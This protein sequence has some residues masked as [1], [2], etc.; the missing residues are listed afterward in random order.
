MAQSIYKDIGGEYFLGAD[1]KY[2]Y[3]LTGETEATDVN[4]EALKTKHGLAS[5]DPEFV[6]KELSKME[7]IT[8]ISAPEPDA[9]TSIDPSVDTLLANTEP[10]IQVDKLAQARKDQLKPQAI[11][12]GTALAFSGIELLMD[13]LAKGQGRQKELDE[14]ERKIGDPGM[15]EAE[16]KQMRERSMVPVRSQITEQRQRQEALQASQGGERSL[17]ALMQ[18]S[19]AG[20]RAI[21]D[22]SLKVDELVTQADASEEMREQARLDR[23]RAERAKYEEARRARQREMLGDLAATAGA[24]IGETVYTVG[25]GKLTIKDLEKKGLNEKQISSLTDSLLK[26]PD[27]DPTAIFVVLR[28]SGVDSKTA[29]ELAPQLAKGQ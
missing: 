4:F 16:K 7:K 25:P 18:Q 26:D 8:P 1:G 27:M 29:M 17:G 21:A 3:R 5:S 19:E 10:T 20:Q 23:I 28:K 9:T 22:A 15:S 6:L 12:G 14:E 11:A 13:E 2:K 24:F